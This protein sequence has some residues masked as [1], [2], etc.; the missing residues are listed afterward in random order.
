LQIH[1]S[2][3][4]HHPLSLLFPLVEK[5]SFCK[6][7]HHSSFNTLS[8]SLLFPLL[9]NSSFFTFIHHSSFIILC[10]SLSS[11]PLENS[12]FANSSITPASSSSLSLSLS[13]VYS[14]LF[15]FNHTFFILSFS[16]LMLLF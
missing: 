6:F 12:S 2:L 5:S 4:L 8:L 14:L 15:L 3:Q 13:L 1:P 16:A 11:L 10:L 7:I 9:E